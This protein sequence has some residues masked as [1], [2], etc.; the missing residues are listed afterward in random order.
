MKANRET[1]RETHSEMIRREAES[2]PRCKHPFFIVRTKPVYDGTADAGES[3]TQLCLNNNA[4]ILIVR[5]E[6]GKAMQMYPIPCTMVETKYNDTGG[7]VFKIP[8]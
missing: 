3:A 5:D 4:F 2:Q 8:V 7:I 1:Y 6:N